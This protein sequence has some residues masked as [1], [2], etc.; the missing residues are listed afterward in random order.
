MAKAKVKRTSTSI[1]MTAMCDVSFLLLTFFVL[2]STFSQPKVLRMIFP[3][4]LDEKDLKN[5]KQPEVK[6]GITILLTRENRVFWYRGALNDKTVLEETDFTKNGLRK[7]LVENNL[8]LLTQLRDFEKQMNKIDDKDTAKRN[9]ID[10]KVKQAQRDSK[11]VVLLKNDDE[12][13]YRNVID[14]M[15]EFM[16]CQIAKY[17]AVD[18]GMAPLEKKLIAQKLKS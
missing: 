3:E 1:D 4:K 13:T 12:A 7:V 9:A 16:I 18:E 6:D 11:L 2:T 5:M 17:F 10:A 14:V 15:D 8:S